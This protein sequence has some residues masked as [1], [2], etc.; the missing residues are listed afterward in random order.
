M[1]GFLY[2]VALQWK[3]D[4]R[5]KTMLITCYV[6]PLLFFAVMGGIFTSIMPESSETLIQSMSV[7][8]FTMES[9]ALLSSCS[10]RV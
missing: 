7:F 5:S 6:V 1:N 9:M 2:G 3:L 10:V 4:L 8:T